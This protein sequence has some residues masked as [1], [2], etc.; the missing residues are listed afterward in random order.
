M[1]PSQR[2]KF[3][4]AVRSIVATNAPRCCVGLGPLCIIC[5]TFM[6][7]C[8]YVNK[9]VD[10]CVCMYVRMHACTCLCLY[11]CMFVCII[12]CA[13]CNGAI[14]Q[15]CKHFSPR[16]PSMLLSIRPKL[17]LAGCEYHVFSLAFPTTTLSSFGPSPYPW[18]LTSA[19]LYLL[20]R[21][22]VRRG[23]NC[24]CMRLVAG[25]HTGTHG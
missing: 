21:L 22:R 3:A 17:L 6:D 24:M 9:F 5:D 15:H 23:R 19:D 7:I 20:R 4:P 1:R 13:R 12:P 10:L 14:V 2:L 25:R 8:I 16:P 11:V 18:V